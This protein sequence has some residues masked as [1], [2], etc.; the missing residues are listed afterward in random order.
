MIL[1]LPGLPRPMRIAGFL[2][3]LLLIRAYG[4]NRYVGLTA[5]GARIQAAGFAFLSTTLGNRSGSASAGK[6]V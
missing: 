5:R 2:A 4:E 3:L 1:A 6:G